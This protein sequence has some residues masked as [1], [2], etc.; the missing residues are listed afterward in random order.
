MLL[1]CCSF[2]EKKSQRL[3]K[4]AGCSI[5]QYCDQKCQ[6]S[7]WKIHKTHC[8]TFKIVKI[9]GKGLGIVASRDIKQG[10]IIIK[11]KAALI[12]PLKCNK[13]TV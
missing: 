3:L 10:E 13:N 9:D 7:H 2:C 11:E 1:E 5:A 12:L 8:K 6:K 4:C